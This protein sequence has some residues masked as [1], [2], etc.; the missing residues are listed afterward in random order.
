MI[1][2]LDFGIELFEDLCKEFLTKKYNFWG[3]ESK[4]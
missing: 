3:R 1:F 2:E 4:Y